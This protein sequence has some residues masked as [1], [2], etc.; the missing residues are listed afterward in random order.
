M[1][2]VAIIILTFNGQ[3]YLPKLLGSIFDCRSNLANFEV[4]VV[5]NCSTDKTVDYINKN[6]S[7]VLVLPQNNNWGFAKGNNI[8]MEYAIKK[9][10]D[11]VF[12]LNQDIIVTVNFL[13][14]LILAIEKDNNLAAVQPLLMLYPDTQKVN[15]LG[16]VIHFLGFGY[17]YGHQQKI[18]E[19]PQNIKEINYC[20]GAACLI[21]TEVLKKIGLFNEDFFMYHE[22]L[23]LGWRLKLMNYRQEV[24]REAIVYHQYEFSRSIKKYYFMERNRFMVI[25]QNYHLLTLILIL[26]ALLLMEIGLFIFS[27]KNGWWQEKLKVYGYFF[28]FKNW[29]KIINHRKITQ[30]LRRKKEKQVVADFSGKIEHQEINNPLLNIINPFFDLYW[31]IVKL[32]IIW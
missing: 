28:D 31:Q 3:K 4:I 24:V 26:P 21:K 10:F 25:L 12:L 23:D 30:R 27:F 17:T 20:S 1:K 29:K 13:D 5:D 32:L 16:N 14:K 8:G 6:F 18:D 9:Q 11:Y 22:D 19:L 2:R 7:Q 15:S